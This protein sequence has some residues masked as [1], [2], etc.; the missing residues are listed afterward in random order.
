MAVH[1]PVAR[2]VGSAKQATTEKPRAA[3][4]RRI[5]FMLK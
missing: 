2:I 5:F 4:R 1:R 3:K